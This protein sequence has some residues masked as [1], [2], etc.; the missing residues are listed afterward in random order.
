MCGAALTV[1]ATA[2]AC[3]FGAPPPDDSGDPPDLPSNSSSSSKS[4]DPSVTSDVVADNLK[5]PWGITFLPDKSALVTERDTGKILSVTPPK[6]KGDK[7][8]VDTVQTVG[9]VSHSGDGGLLGIAA[10][11]DYA[12]DKT[13]YIYYTTDSD[14]RIAKLKDGGKPKPIV[15][16]IPKSDT[17]NGGQLAF[18]PDG[19]LYATTGDAEKADDA[20]DKKSLAGK[21]LRMDTKGKA[22]SDN[23]FGKS[24]VYSYGHRDSAG[25]AWDSKKRLYATEFGDKEDELNKIKPGGNY[26]W[27]QV[28]GAS[29]GGTYESP[30]TTWKTSEGECAGAAFAESAMVTACLTGQRLRTFK[31]DKKGKLD[32][33]PAES[34]NNE[35]G[36]LRAVAAAPDG[37]LWIS[38]SNRE[39]GGQPHKGDDK[40]IRVIAGGSAEG[41]T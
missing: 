38:T 2:S 25:L 15:T 35:L 22:P 13:V 28:E 7:A 34:Q 17:R 29:S 4:A 14:N 37:T 36:R 11:P 6:N 1:L 33:K 26:G 41:Q 21:I 30:V 31:F 18:G 16:G 27:P 3:S 20:Q 9:G 32:G 40:I 24:L 8:K 12:K 10:S 19:D 23:P 39:H 5:V